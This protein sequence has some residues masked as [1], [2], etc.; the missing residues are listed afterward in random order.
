MLLCRVK[1]YIKKYNNIIVGSA[2][3]VEGENNVVIGS[4]NNLTGQNSW[5]FASNYA[6]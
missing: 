1:A 3:K 6:S 2:N 5:I 4:Y